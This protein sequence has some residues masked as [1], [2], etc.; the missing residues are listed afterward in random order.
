[1]TSQY[2]ILNY[3]SV[4][5]SEF[6]NIAVF[7]YDTDVDKSETYLA[8]VKDWVGVN[9]AAGD[10]NDPVF[11]N[12]LGS[13]LREINTKELLQNKIDDSQAPYSVFMFG[14]PQDS[15]MAADILA[16]EVA[17]TLLVE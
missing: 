3:R 17:K 13:F 6:V 5:T 11:E 15:E 1:M 14:A 7:S 2:I 8:F 4:R 12:L 9:N 16:E 10:P